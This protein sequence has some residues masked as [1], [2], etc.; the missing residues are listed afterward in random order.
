MSSRSDSMRRRDVVGALGALGAAWLVG[1][2]ARTADGA[3]A[4]EA[5]ERL[6][7]PPPGQ[8]GE[9]LG[10][11]TH[12]LALASGRDGLLYV[13]PGYRADAPAPLVVSFHG[14]GGSAQRWLT[15]VT[16][17]ADTAGCV[18]LVPDSRDRT[19]DVVVEG[20]FGADVAF[21]NRALQLAF[22]RL[23]IDPRRLALQ[24]FSDGA[25][26]ALSLGLT[27]GD[28]FTRLAAFSPGFLVPAPRR[29]R[30]ALFVSHGT[31]D[32][33]LPIDRCSRIIVPALRT[34]GY[35]VQ[36]QEFDG[37][38]TVPAAQAAAAF[39]WLGEPTY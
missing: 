38:H 29:G 32:E 2:R 6:V 10:P 5:P 3:P 39:R 27:N 23:A 9:P 26:Y 8:R 17:L 21:V 30:P 16:G 34:D 19:W 1:C 35:A 4:Q 12:P 37:P 13:P 36:Y 24:G 25:S 7:V 22:T 31:A 11:G 18:L 14:A 20:Q 33:I 15:R 28:R